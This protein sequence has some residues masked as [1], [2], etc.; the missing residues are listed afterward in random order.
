VIYKRPKSIVVPVDQYISEYGSEDAAKMRF[1]NIGSGTWTHPC[2]S[3]LDLPAQTPEF[4][5]I[6]A[7]CIHHDLVN[8]SE[9]PIATNS[10]HAFYC[11]HVVEHLPE[12]AVVNLMKEAF[13]C[14]EKGGVFRIVTGPCADLD[15]QALLRSDKHWWFWN[16][17]INF[18]ESVEK[19]K[20]PM[21]VYDRWLYHMATPRS[22]HSRTPCDKKYSSAEIA[23][24]VSAHESNPQGLWNLLTNSLEFNKSSPGDHLSW[25]NHDKLSANLFKVGFTNVRRSGYGQ[26]HLLWMRDLRYFDQT[27]PQVS[28][29]VEA[30]K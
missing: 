16:D 22:F 17:D 8:Q 28:V 23:A 10:A 4:A 7:P 13:R 26:S 29:Y 25:W 5:A 12:H 24:L 30:T 20:G 3:N 14:L 19:D 15:W 21:T 9:L 27:Y 18:K 1:F 2:W 11:S 6:Q